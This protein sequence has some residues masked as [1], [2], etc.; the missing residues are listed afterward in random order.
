MKEV[1]DLPYYATDLPCPLP[2]IDEIQNAPDIVEDGWRRVVAV[3]QHYVVKFGPQ[4]HLAEGQ[5][6]LFVRQTTKNINLPRVYA[7]Y[8]DENARP[9]PQSYIVMER[10]AGKTLLAAWPDLTQPEKQ[11]IMNSLRSQIDELRQLP[12]PGYFGSVGK[13][14]LLD[15]I[16]WTSEPDPSSN[17]P[18]ESEEELNEAMVLNYGL[19]SDITK[20]FPYRQAYLRKCFPLIFR[21]HKAVFTHGDFQRKNIMIRDEAEE[22]EDDK[23]GENRV[24]LIDWQF[25]GWYPEYWEHCNA[26]CALHYKDDWAIWLDTAIKPYIAETAWMQQIRLE[27][28]A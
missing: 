11:V 27:L 25:S 1:V 8:R 19:N 5:H 18:F 14:Q 6:M 10:I 26:V 17:G 12:A 20:S 13:T 3:N 7:L 28:W 21:G 2:T 23:G 9:V 22:G 4:V 15:R 16:F 24:V